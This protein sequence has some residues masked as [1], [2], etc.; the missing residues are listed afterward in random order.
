[1]ITAL[2]G[3]SACG[4]TVDPR[5]QAAAREAKLYHQQ[6]VELLALVNCAHRH[7]INLPPPTPTNK[8]STRGVNLKSPQRKAALS[9]CYHKVVG[10]FA[11]QQS[12][13]G[14]QEGKSTQA[15][16][17]P[18][19]S[20]AAV[21]REHEQLMEL[22]ACARRHGIR[23]PEPDAQNH[24]NTRGVNLKGHKREVIMSR[25][26]HAVVSHATH[27]REAANREQQQSPNGFGE[28][29]PA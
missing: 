12:A 5:A 6:H 18:S 16:Q 4:S 13:Q 26:F 10:Q 11:G 9:A 27:E 8:V 3:L 17:A 2:A 29:P 24:V 28:E 15:N 22:V 1:M 25:C 19:Q 21:A 23:L 7:G 20:P 14:A